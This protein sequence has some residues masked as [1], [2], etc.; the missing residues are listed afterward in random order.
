MVNAEK[1][2]RFGEGC[3][4]NIGR[5][6]LDWKLRKDEWIDSAQGKPC[7]KS[8]L[9]SDQRSS[10]WWPSKFLV[11][12]FSA[13]QQRF[14]RPRLVWGPG[15]CISQKLW[16]WTWCEGLWVSEQCS[17]KH[18]GSISQTQAPS[19]PCSSL[20]PHPLP[21]PRLCSYQGKQE[22]TSWGR[23]TL[24]KRMETLA[25][26]GEISCSQRWFLLLAQAFPGV[27]P[28]TAQWTLD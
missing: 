23:N 16:G 7:A 18:G 8:W 14:W 2:I 1:E 10:L 24:E 13:K 11:E 6:L 21:G 27:V 9:C 15:I 20:P 19:T 26:W 12:L 28:L 3:C 4:E 22:K 25:G 17:K 5:C